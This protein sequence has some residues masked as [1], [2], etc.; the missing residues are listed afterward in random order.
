MKMR[1]TMAD[2]ATGLAPQL[3][4]PL[5]FARHTRQGKRSKSSVSRPFMGIAT[6]AVA[7][8][9][10]AMLLAFAVSRGFQHEVALR[11]TGFVGHVQI[12]NLDANNSFEQRPIAREQPF[13]P[14]LQT[15]RHLEA[16]E[17]FAIK[18]GILKTPGDMQGCVLKGLDS[19]ADLS[20]FKRFLVRGH[21]PAL[22]T[23]QASGDVLISQTIAEALRLDT[24]ESLTMYFV[25]QPPRV[26]RFRIV[27]IFNTQFQE[28]DATYIYGDLRHIQALNGW[29]PQQIGG[30]QLR[31]DDLAN[32]DA[33]YEQLQELTLGA[34][35]SDGSLLHIVDVREKHAALFDWLAL[36]DMNVL[37]LLLLMLAVAGVNMSCALLILILEK[38]KT[39]GLLK[40]LGASTQ[41]IASIF[42]LQ[43]SRILLRGLLVGNALGLTIALGQKYGQ[44]VKLDPEEYYMDHVPILLE[45]QTAL[46]INLVTMVATLLI[47]L[48]PAMLI[49]RVSPSETIR[50]A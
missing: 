15:I 4:F 35:Q 9:V 14:Q 43:A 23:P 41:Q 24:G 30:Y 36:L 5:Y 49:A 26:R 44:F 33:V 7:V 3:S 28:F 25:Q 32:I 48:L 38:T 19:T 2:S 16:V 20:F 47:L 42:L 17:P 12:V 22:N 8:S 29:T 39:I 34:L 10:A 50:Y 11:A 40:A 1:D 13:L 37:I 27:G 31:V 21:L 46:G 6:A 18:P 45:W